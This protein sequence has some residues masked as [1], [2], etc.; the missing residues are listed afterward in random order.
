MNDDVVVTPR[1]WNDRGEAVVYAPSGKPL[2]VHGGIPGETA[3][4]WIQ[5]RGQNQS[6]ALWRHA[7][8][9]SPSRVDP[10][11]DKVTACGGCPLLHVDAAGQWLAREGL[12]RRAL[13]AHGLEDVSISGR[14]DGEDGDLGYRHVVKLGA[15][16]SDQGSVRMGAWGRRTRTIVPIPKCPVTTDGIRRVMSALAHHVIQQDIRPYE[17]Q[18]ESGILRSAVI[19]ES[20]TTGEILVTLV[21]AKRIRQLVELA[22]AVAQ[23]VSEV[24]GVWAH[25]NQDPGNNIFTRDEWGA[26]KVS[27]LVGKAWIEETVDEVSYRMGPGDFFQ[28]NPAVADVLYRRVFERL[29]LQKGRAVVDLYCGVGGMA[30]Q[31]ARKTGW[32]LGVEAVE[33]AVDHARESAKRNG[34]AA[35]FICEDVFHAIPD[36]EKRLAGRRPVVMVNPARRGLED[37]VIEAIHRLNPVKIAYVSCNPA[38]L[39]RDLTAFRALGYAV[40]D[41]DLF[42]MFPNTPHVESVAILH[43][44][45]DDTKSR[46]APQRRVVRKG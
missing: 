39:A 6:L 33:G 34:I 31:A 27:P 29:E 41:L 13:D 25:I 8:N 24:V 2:L 10:P 17:P 14:I 20:R 12:V 43:G 40:E 45:P 38:A 19:R 15:G 16:Y 42:N 32:A 35:E 28:T 9:P 46:R 22:E 30:L 5:V 7:Q 44:A 18:T 4:A 21:V 26:V 3:T 23:D 11:C 36:V 1:E 37:G